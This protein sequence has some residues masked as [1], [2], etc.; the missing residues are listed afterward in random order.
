MIAEILATGDEVR[1]GALVDSNSAHI[2]ERLTR[3]GI[4]VQR[5]H[6]VGDDMQALVAVF[7]EISRRADIAVVTGGLGPTQDDLTVEAAARAAGCSLRLD[8]RVLRDIE[9]FFVERGRTMSQSNKK[10]A[11]LPEKATVLYNPVGTAPGFQLTLNRCVFFCLPGVPYEMKTMLADQVLP[12][13]ESLQGGRRSYNLARTFATFGLPE[14]TV[15]EKVLGL[16]TAF[17]GIKVGLR[18]K[19]PEIQV[20]LYLAANDAREGEALL[21][22]AG[23]WV[24]DR[25][26]AFMFS[27]EGST[28][29]ETVGKMLADRGQ[30]LALA[31]SCTGGLVANWITNI[32]GSSDYFLLSAVTYA[33]QAKIDILGVKPETLAQLGAVDEQVAREMAQGARRRSGATYGVGITGIAGPGGATPG[34]PVGTV[35][36]A[37]AAPDKTISKRFVFSF[38]RRLMNKKIFATAALDLLRRVMVE[39]VAA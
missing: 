7:D 14:S 37:V 29:A 28:M 10:Q 9:R 39:R 36:I 21:D 15:G 5:H 22:K 13:L 27:D 8:D 30:T 16:E 38:G 18:A 25:L 26:G 35:C 34:K 11:Y 33:N 24:A 1:T 12:E 4:F 3:T 20:K 2:A 17:P 23:R 19:F 32:A 31:E 6:T